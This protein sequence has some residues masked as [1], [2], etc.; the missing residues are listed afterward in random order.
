MNENELDLE[1]ADGV[2]VR[3]M[4]GMISSVY[5]R[6]EAADDEPAEKEKK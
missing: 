4:R 5:A 3:T 2:R 6:T 1:I